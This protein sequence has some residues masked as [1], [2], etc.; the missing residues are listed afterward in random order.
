MHLL[1]VLTIALVF[2]WMQLEKK[3]K[4][5]DHLVP[6]CL[7][8]KDYVLEPG[9][10]CTVIGWGKRENNSKSCESSAWGGDDATTEFCLSP[11]LVS[12]YEPAALE[13]VV[14]I[15]PNDICN[16]WLLDQKLSITEGMMCA[17]YEVGGTDACQV[18]SCTPFIVFL[19]SFLFKVAFSTS[20][21]PSRL[22]RS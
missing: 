14:P 10:N 18:G 2:C 15:L 3:V 11:F 9:T 1:N 7:P 12:Q 6:V 20:W 13:A 22:I 16:N 5:H 8:S 4:F 21:I 17:G 19:R